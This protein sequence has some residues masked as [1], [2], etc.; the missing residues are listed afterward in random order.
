MMPSAAHRIHHSP[1]MAAS[2]FKSGLLPICL[3]ILSA[4]FNA[5]LAIVNARV[6]PLSGNIVILCEVL[7]VAS[8]HIY[9]LR[10]FQA[11]MLNWYFLALAF[12]IFA[13]LRITATDNL[14][15]KYFRDIFLIVTFV[16]LG[17]TSND[18][19]VIQMM[20]ALQIAVIAGIAL[21]AA[22]IEC[23]GEL[24]AVKDFYINTRGVSES[25]FTNLTSDLYVS[26]T[27]PEARFLPFFDLHRLSS[28]FLE[29]VSLG[30]F[31][32]MTVAFTAAFWSR[33][34]RGLQALFVFSIVLMLFACDGRLAMLA[35]VAIVA[36]SAG[37]RYVPRH[38]ALLFLPV[39]AA[40]AIAV[41]DTG[42]LRS[43]TDDLAGRIAYTAE[44]LSGMKF[45][46]VA[47]LSD[48]LLELSVDA[49]AVYLIITQSFLG[50]ALLWAFVT[51]AADESTREQKIYKNGLLLYLALT[52]MVSYSFASIKTAAPIWF[53]FGA[54]LSPA[55]MTASKPD[56]DDA[57]EFDG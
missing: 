9:I 24:F 40:L 45:L 57:G 56:Q 17:M 21:E 7:I 14:D 23:Y 8:A 53:V 2:A 15:A 26:A 41:T 55:A 44:L 46:D 33:L 6:K 38:A 35:T 37:Y 22:C 49:G 3:V 48:R 52:M 4:L 28:I 36:M 51:L 50:V 29:P 39:V 25:D 19:R 20:A 1:P 32:I 10:H 13:I 43:G 30:N 34:G 12:A 16:L 54:L 5:G 31:V 18:R 27:R 11:R 42:G 47:G